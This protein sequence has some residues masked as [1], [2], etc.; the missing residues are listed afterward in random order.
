MI[1]ESAM[2]AENEREVHVIALAI[3][4]SCLQDPERDLNQFFI[5]ITKLCQAQSQALCNDF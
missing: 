2:I 5:M 4:P 1:T 3:N